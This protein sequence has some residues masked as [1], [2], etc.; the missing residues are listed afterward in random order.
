MK[1]CTNCGKATNDENELFCTNCGYVFKSE[2]QKEQKTLNSTEEISKQSVPNNQKMSKKKKFGLIT[3]LSLFIL[4]LIGHF[5]IKTMISPEKMIKAMNDDFT[6]EKPKDFLKHFDYDQKINADAEGYYDYIDDQNWST[7]RDQ[8]LTQTQTLEEGGFVDPITDS[9]NNNMIK[10]VEKPFLAGLYKK[11]SFEIVPINLLVAIEFE[12]N[13]DTVDDYSATFK[14]DNDSIDLITDEWTSVGSYL[15]GSYEW[16]TEI[17]NQFGD[18]PFSGSMLLGENINDNEEK[19]TLVLDA[20][21]LTIETNNTD[22]TLFINGKS[23]DTKIYDKNEIGPLELD[24]SVTVQ[25]KVTDEGKE[26]KTKSVKATKNIIQL[27]F[28]YIENQERQ[29]ELNELVS[30][31]E[32]SLENLFLSYRQAHEDTLNSGS[33]SYIGD[34]IASSKLAGDFVKLAKADP[35]LKENNHTNNILSITA[36]DENNFSLLSEEKYTFYFDDFRIEEWKLSRVYSIEYIDGSFKITKAEIDRTTRQNQITRTSKEAK[37]AMEEFEDSYGMDYED[38][39]DD[40]DYYDYK[41]F[42]HDGYEDV[43]D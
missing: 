13:N 39:F 32:Y 7:I 21:F 16:D 10:I 17:Q 15:P 31:N 35:L 18:L 14:K 40:S 3:I 27:N 29:E 12:N 34:Y 37:V 9:N 8:L 43:K 22:A 41:Y 4:L 5:T 2:D 19:L 11:L 25:A 24:G 33:N 20:K 28:D 26:Y 42:I 6:A 36:I 23:T 30:S 1:F 38:Y